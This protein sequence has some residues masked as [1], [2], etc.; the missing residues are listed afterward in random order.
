MQVVS[1]GISP[2]PPK[3]LLPL[4]PTSHTV[5]YRPKLRWTNPVLAALAFHVSLTYIYSFCDLYFDLQ[6]VTVWPSHRSL[7]SS[8]SSPKSRH[9]RNIQFSIMINCK[10]LFV[11]FQCK[12][13]QVRSAIKIVQY[14]YNKGVSSLANREFSTEEV[15]TRGAH[16]HTIFVRFYEMLHEIEKNLVRRYSVAGAPLDPPVSLR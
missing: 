11:L 4:L 9:W 14:H 16:Q 10:S 15:P 7:K 6:L 3:N 13:W 1:P 12:M 5:A 2:A 8:I